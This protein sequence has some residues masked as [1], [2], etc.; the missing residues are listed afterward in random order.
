MTSVCKTLECLIA[1]AREESQA[2]SLTTVCRNR[3]LRYVQ[4]SPQLL[5]SSH[6]NYL[7]ALNLTYTWLLRHL[8]TFSQKAGEELE[9]TFFRWV[10]GH[11]KWRIKD[12]RAELSSTYSLDQAMGQDSESETYLDQTVETGW[13]A[14]TLE[15]LDALLLQDDQEAIQEIF[16]QF[17]HYVSADPEGRLQA[18]H[19]RR[20]P[21]CNAQALCQQVLLHSP[22]KQLRTI[23]REVGI[24]EQTLYSH[25][26]K[27]CK[28]LLRDIL[29]ELGYRPGESE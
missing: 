18:C 28:P 25:W 20:Y 7:E 24:N 11:L 10:N 21:E 8:D 1:E 5:H 19:P 9:T 22:Q 2:A 23:S 17:E 16:A 3:L 12:L 4:R 15:G 13:Q 6:S 27:K 26:E 14:P 29:W